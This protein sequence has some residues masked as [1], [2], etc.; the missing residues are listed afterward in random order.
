M[1][2]RLDHG[3]PV[4][5]AEQIAVQV[6]AGIVSGELV[7]GERLPP[8]RD[9]GVALGVNMHTVLRA[10]AALRE[11]GLIEMRQGRG[12]W[13]R[14]DAGPVLVRLK[15]LAGQLVAEG[16]KLGLTR[17]ELVRLIERT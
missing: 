1:L 17:P 15:E 14:Q 12:A 11:D 7:A 9:L 10:Y 6:R 3:S 8:A 5:L 16:R 13:V 2:F 4:S